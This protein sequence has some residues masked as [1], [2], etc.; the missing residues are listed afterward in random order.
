MFKRFLCGV[1]VLFSLPILAAC[2]A[3]AVATSAKGNLQNSVSSSLNEVN[4]P[5]TSDNKTYRG[6]VDDANSERLT[7]SQLPGYDYGQ[8]SIVF[9][10]S[11]DTIVQQNGQELVKNCYVEVEY[12][13]TLTRSLPPQGN[14]IKISIIAL[15]SDNVILNGSVQN[16]KKAESGYL[17]Q[18]QPFDESQPI[19]TLI[20]PANASEFLQEELPKGTKL[21]VVTRGTTSL[22]YPPQYSVY[23]VLLYSDT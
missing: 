8:E 23:K 10:I 15:Y 18:L 22:T 12:D 16:I 17:L 2:G 14:A 4:A 20:V 6:R 7:V 1:A 19:V 13:G 9:A 5:S 3:N 11:P 21:S